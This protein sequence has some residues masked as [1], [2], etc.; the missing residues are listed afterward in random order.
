MVLISDV[1][2][3]SLIYSFLLFCSLTDHLHEVRGIPIRSTLIV[4][5]HHCSHIKLPSFFWHTREPRLSHTA[6]CFRSP[7]VIHRSKVCSLIVRQWCPRRRPSRTRLGQSREHHKYSKQDLRRIS[8]QERAPSKREPLVGMLPTHNQAQEHQRKNNLCLEVAP[9]SIK[10]LVEDQIKL[11]EV[12]F[13]QVKR[14]RDNARTIGSFKSI[15]SI[16]LFYLIEIN[17]IT[18]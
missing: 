12:G 5:K 14:A 11:N 15:T 8:G 18:Q 4:N 16:T 1:L 7:A 10:R 13:N 17:P 6:R 2:G 3:L 9:T